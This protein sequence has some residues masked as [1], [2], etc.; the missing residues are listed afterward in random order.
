MKVEISNH[1]N[2]HISFFCAIDS[3]ITNIPLNVSFMH[4]KINIKYKLYFILHDNSSA[5]RL[6]SDYSG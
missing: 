3:K 6:Q 1:M 5:Q 4:C 2:V